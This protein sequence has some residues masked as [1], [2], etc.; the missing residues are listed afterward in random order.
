MSGP[1][2]TNANV[3]KI[4]ASTLID[5]GIIYSCLYIQ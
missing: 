5:S 1:D 3:T 4:K 2:F